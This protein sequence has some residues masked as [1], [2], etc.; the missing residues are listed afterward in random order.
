MKQLAGQ[1]I[2]TEMMVASG[3]SEPKREESIRGGKLNF[4]GQRT[5]EENETGISRFLSGAPIVFMA[6][7][8]VRRKGI[9]DYSIR[10]CVFIGEIPPARLRVEW[11]EAWR[12]PNQDPAR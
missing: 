8:Y 3:K 11:S 5:T 9:P 10:I 12:R 7:A 4:L 2:M 6:E 1:E